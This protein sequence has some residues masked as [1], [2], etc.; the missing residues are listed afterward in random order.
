M[1]AGPVATRTLAAWG[2]D[3]VRLSLAQTARSPTGA[4]IAPWQAAH[5]DRPKEHLVTLPGAAHPV[6]VIAPPGQVGDQVPAWTST[7]DFGS[8]PPAFRGSGG[9]GTAV[10]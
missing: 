3:V 4:G 1:I 5:E 6:H 2:A 8:D 10:R 9:P 7:T